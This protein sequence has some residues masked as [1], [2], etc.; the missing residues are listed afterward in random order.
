MS[1]ELKD[2]NLPIRVIAAQQKW[3]YHFAA[4][5]PVTPDGQRKLVELGNQG[6]ELVTVVLVGS[7]QGIMVF[8]R[9]A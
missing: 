5:E 7:D 8:K 4:F 6:W 3:E 9:P 2:E 1:H